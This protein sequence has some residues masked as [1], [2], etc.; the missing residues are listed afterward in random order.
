MMMDS[1]GGWTANSEQASAWNGDAGKHWVAHQDRYDAMS[2]P[3][4]PPCSR[5]RRWHLPTRYWTSAAD[6]GTR[7][8]P[9]AVP[10]GAVMRS[11]STYPAR[12][13]SG[14]GTPR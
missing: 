3:F 11:A 8:A 12:C 7:P 1:S 14:R 6:A 2:E 5:R 10:P 13:L 9:P 4:T